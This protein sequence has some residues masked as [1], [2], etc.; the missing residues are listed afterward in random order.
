MNAR[1]LRGEGFSFGLW[2]KSKDS[3][4]LNDLFSGSPIHFNF[5]KNKITGSITDSNIF[6]SDRTKTDF[7]FDHE[8]SLTDWN[9]LVTS[10]DQ[11]KG[12]FSVS[13]NG[14]KIGSVEVPKSKFYNFAAFRLNGRY[15][16]VVD[17]IFFHVQPIADQE[18]KTLHREEVVRAMSPISTDKPVA[19]KQIKLKAYL[20]KGI[21]KSMVL[22]R[23]KNGTVKKLELDEHGEVV[24]PELEANQF[25]QWM[26]VYI[27][28]QGKKKT[29][30]YSFR[31]VKQY[32]QNGDFESSEESWEKNDFTKIVKHE[33]A[34]G[35]NALELTRNKPVT[36]K[37]GDSPKTADKL[38]KLDLN[39]INTLDTG[40]GRVWINLFVGD[41]HILRFKMNFGVH[42][43]LQDHKW[44]FGRLFTL[45]KDQLGKPMRL[46]FDYHPMHNPG[47]YNHKVLLDNL[48][49]VEVNK[50]DVNLAPVM[51]EEYQEKVLPYKKGLTGWAYNIRKFFKDPE[52]SPVSIR[53][54]SG[55]KWLIVQTDDLMSPFGPSDDAI[56]KEHDVVI[57]AR[58]RSG[59][60]AQFTLKVKAVR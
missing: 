3:Q 52:G 26:I 47:N 49:L 43:V 20:G 4:D 59:S 56:G 27:T 5:T 13:L 58:D 23:G 22:L 24:I 6:E 8:S 30:K 14:T 10:L 25:Y 39:L 54:V 17:D 45:T 28:S 15:D 19:N 37:L 36:F 21:K 11:V 16:A 31:T 18:I 34:S 12:H 48:S 60:K 9:Y 57:E 42:S 53:I 35:Q 29:E 41:H 40:R 2:I 44:G 38:L 7:S 33:R 32:V 46:V 55:P 51:L 50:A 1:V